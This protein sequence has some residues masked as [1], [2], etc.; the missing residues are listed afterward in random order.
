MRLTLEEELLAA[1]LASNE[2]LTEA[3][4]MYEDLERV[5]IERET[6][7][8]SRKETRIDRNVSDLTYMTLARAFMLLSSNCTTI[9][10]D[11]LT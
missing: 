7:A 6:E 5:G 8:R 1:L 11:K 2:E 9:K 4:K 3:L 10:T